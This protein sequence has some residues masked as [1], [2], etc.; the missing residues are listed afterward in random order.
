MISI[1]IDFQNDAKNLKI[2]SRPTR[3]WLPHSTQMGKFYAIANG[4][5]PGV[6]SM[7]WADV[8]GLVDGYEGTIIT[9][10]TKFQQKIFY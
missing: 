7:P 6:Y 1:S 10:M 8:K 4:Y 5:Q 3:T 2:L 9:E